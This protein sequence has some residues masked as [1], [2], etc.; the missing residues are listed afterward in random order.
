M[1]QTPGQERPSEPSNAAILEALANWRQGFRKTPAS[2]TFWTLGSLAFLT[3]GLIGFATII[4]GWA[5]LWSLGISLLGSTASCSIAMIVNR[6]RR[7]GEDR[8]RLLGLLVYLS[9]VL[10]GMSA[11]QITELFVFIHSLKIA[12][13][14]N[15]PA[16]PPMRLSTIVIS[17]LAFLIFYVGLAVTTFTIAEEIAQVVR[18]AERIANA[19]IRVGNS[20]TEQTPQ[21]EDAERQPP[22]S[23]A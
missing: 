2:Y 14:L 17:F 23:A 19:L 15:N 1:T 18:L 8:A 9:F 22:E 12:E 7:R 16:F 3:T 4:G 13:A 10:V 6:R 20:K 5:N 21:G 11:M